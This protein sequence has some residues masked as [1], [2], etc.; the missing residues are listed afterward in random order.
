M[1]IKRYSRI[2]AL[3]FALTVPGLGDISSLEAQTSSPAA[4][5]DDVVQSCPTP[6]ALAAFL[7]KEIALR[8]DALSF[9]AADYWQTPEEFLGNKAG[10]CEDYALLAQA[11]LSRQGV[12]AFVFSLYGEGKYAHTVCVFRDAG[13][14]NVVNNDRVV[15]YR[16][17]SLEEL[18]TLL[19]PKW[20][21]GAVAEKQGHRGRALKGIRNPSL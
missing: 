5:L 13:G 20:R 6:E 15:R 12:E 18:A 9:A 2:L 1:E 4:T 14:Y 19:Y 10:D 3:F 17:K 11:V 16:A 21:W 8:E 7:A